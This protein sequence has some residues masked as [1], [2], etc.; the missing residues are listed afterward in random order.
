MKL[1]KEAANKV[2]R[3]VIY[4]KDYCNSCLFYLVITVSLWLSLCLSG[5]HK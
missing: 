4:E 3:D 2:S 5:Y 1:D